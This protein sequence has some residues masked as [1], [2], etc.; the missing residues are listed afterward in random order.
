MARRVLSSRL[1]LF[2]K[3]VF[4]P[5]FIAFLA[6]VGLGIGTPYGWV[7]VP[8]IMLFLLVWYV[9]CG[10]LLSVQTD[11]AMLYVSNYWREIQVP[12][13]EV[14]KITEDILTNIHPVTIH[15]SRPTEFGVRIRFMPKT[16]FLFFSSHPV[17]AELKQ[18]VAQAKAM[19]GAE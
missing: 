1:T 16:K 15:L 9:L 11:H 10:R 4:P 6:I 14:S 3:F 17:V 19:G 13:S 8:M 2:Y 5:L 7:A 12:L 18:L